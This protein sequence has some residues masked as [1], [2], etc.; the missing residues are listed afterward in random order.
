MEGRTFLK[1]NGRKYPKTEGHSFQMERAHGASSTMN[2]KD[3]QF[4][5]ISEHKG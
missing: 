4:Y 1:N 3:S 2:K 5:K